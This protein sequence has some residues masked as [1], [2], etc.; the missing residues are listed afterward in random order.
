MNRLFP[1]ALRVPQARH[2]VVLFDN[3]QGVGLGLRA[4]RL[5]RQLLGFQPRVPQARHLVAP[6]DNHP[7]FLRRDTWWS[8]STTSKE[9][10]SA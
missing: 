2:L 7:G 4:G 10:A 5:M 9:S 6:F 3:Q 8:L 1:L